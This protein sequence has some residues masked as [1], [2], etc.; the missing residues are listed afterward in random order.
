MAETTIEQYIDWVDFSNTVPPDQISK[1]KDLWHL[2]RYVVF[3]NQKLNLTN[4]EDIV[5]Y[6][7][8]YLKDPFI[9]PIQ[10]SNYVARVL[11]ESNE[12]SRL[13]AGS[14]HRDWF[15]LKHPPKATALYAIDIPSTGGDTLFADQ[16]KA[17]AEL[18]KHLKKIVDT[19]IGINTAKDGYSPEGIYGK[20]DLNRSMDLYFSDDAYEKQSHPLKAIHP[21]TGQPV[22]NCDPGYTIG[23]QGLNEAE[24][25]EI[26]DEIFKHQTDEKYIYKHKWQ[27]GDLVL[28]DNRCLIHKAT[29]GYDGQRRLLHR[30]TIQ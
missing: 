23:I 14:W 3:P 4:L 26:L 22:I 9:N 13:F 27:V 11:R 17:Y 25:R 30:V 29:G 7:G 24:S 28:W 21:A 18:P 8:H 19:M 16:Y 6:F 2:Y 15:H 10:G 5:L 1:I 20:D 12:T